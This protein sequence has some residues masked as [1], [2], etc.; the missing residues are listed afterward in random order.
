MAK[1]VLGGVRPIKAASPLLI[2]ALAAVGL[3]FSGCP[4]RPNANQALD[5]QL[6]EMKTHR[7]PLAKFAGRVTLDGQ[8]PKIGLKQT[9]LVLLY[10]PKHPPDPRHPPLWSHCKEDGTFEFTTYTRNDGVPPGSYTVLFAGLTV[11]RNGYGLPDALKGLYNDPDSSTFKA[12]V[13]DAG[14]TDYLFELATVG[15]D[16]VRPGPHAI[17]R[18]PRR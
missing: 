15:K 14:K 16:A 12:D 17:T 13:T 11:S 1:R 3:F 18:I 2:A 9:L 7:V 5:K 10:D 6:E 8:P 4:K